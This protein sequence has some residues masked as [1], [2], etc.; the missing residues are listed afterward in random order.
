MKIKRSELIAKTLH[1]IKN[2]PV[3]LLV[4]PRQ[5]GKTTLA[6]EI[7]ALKGGSYFDL[8]D[9]ET[10]LKPEIAQFVLKELRGLVVIDEF[11]RQPGLF[12]LLRVLADRRPIS[13]RFLILGSASLDIVKGVSESLAGRVAY[14]QMSGFMLNEINAG[15]MNKLWIRGSFP[16]S[17]LAKSESLSYEWRTNFIQSFLERDIPQ[18]GIRIP[19]SALR[20]FWIMLAHYHGQVWNAAELARSI[21]VKEDTA[22]R[23][24]D[25]LTG[26]FLIRQLPPWFENLGKRLVKA[27][28]VFIRDSGLLHYL[29]SL[30]NREQVLSH[31]KAGFSWEGF[32]LEQV[33]SMTGFERDAYF[34]RTHGGA[35]LDCLIISGK[36]RYGFEF[37]FK[38]APFITKSMH[39]VCEDLDLERLFVIYPGTKAYPLSDKIEAVPLLKLREVLGK[40]K[41]LKYTELKER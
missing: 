25:V 36:K 21:G 10:A 41:L 24:L 30:K 17:F 5:C 1:A 19:A 38:D 28:K 16:L 4:G 13:A 11:Q 23:Y 27:P 26:T 14:I 15:D 40:Y 2:F 35:E 20:K 8:E 22:R 33:L 29:L 3:T 6:R 7:F 34:Y 9:P 31:P 37:K 39:V 18:L 32:A 12:P